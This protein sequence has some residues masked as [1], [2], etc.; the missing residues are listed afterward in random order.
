LG[1]KFFQELFDF[2]TRHAIG[3]I[4]QP[5]QILCELTLIPICR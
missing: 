5:S 3:S 2:L 4:L 1:H